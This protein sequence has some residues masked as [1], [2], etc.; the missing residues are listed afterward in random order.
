VTRLPDD[1]RLYDAMIAVAEKRLDK[2]GLAEIFRR[3]AV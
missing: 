3:A 1:I 2:A